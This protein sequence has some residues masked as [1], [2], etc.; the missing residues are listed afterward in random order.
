VADL[1]AALNDAVSDPA[2]AERMGLAGRKRAVESF[3]WATIG[4]QTLA[5]YRDVL[6]DRTPSS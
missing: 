1:A 2:R 4:E 3:S 6:R 5:V